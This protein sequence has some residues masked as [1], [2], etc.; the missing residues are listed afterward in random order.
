MSGITR[1]HYTCSLCGWRNDWPNNNTASFPCEQC[2]RVFILCGSRILDQGRYDYRP[3]YSYSL[4]RMVDPA[5]SLHSE[6]E[7]ESDACPRAEQSSSAT[8]TGPSAQSAAPTLTPSA[9]PALQA[10]LKREVSHEERLESAIIELHALTGLAAVK[11][12]VDQLIAFARVQSIR[13]QKGLRSPPLS[14][15]LVFTG[16]P[17]TG[18]TTVARIIGEVFNAIGLLRKADVV[19]VDR[20]D[21]VAGYVGQ[22]AIKAKAQID[23]ALGGVLFIDEAYTLVGR[24]GDFGQE[25]IDTLLKAME[26]HRDDL[27][28]IVA[29]YEDNMA[30]FLD[31]NPGLRSR[32]NTFIHFE[33]YGA[34]ELTSIFTGMAASA[35]YV[36]S[37]AAH[38]VLLRCF[39]AIVAAP[40]AGFSNARYARNLFENTIRHQAQRL[41]ARSTFGASDLARLDADD[42]SMGM[43]DL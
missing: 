28:V 42:V 33:D 37:E 34:S 7:R 39:Q 31:S 10:V 1:V 32:F 23:R 9:P 22:T 20:S 41:A 4:G 5:T 13:R 36:V 26:D 25:A 18:K 14:K 40:P 15:H 29:G 8:T 16:N 38:V 35:D 27:L 24:E 19:E 11:Q 12:R 17:G 6:V 3:Y 2:R 43:R 21:L 30:G